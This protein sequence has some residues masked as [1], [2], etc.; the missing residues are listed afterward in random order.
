MHGGDIAAMCENTES[1]AN[2]I[3]AAISGTRFAMCGLTVS[4][5]ERTLILAFRADFEDDQRTC[6]KAGVISVCVSTVSP[7]SDH[8]LP[9]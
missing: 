3:P 9:T 2:E 6:N 1:I 7:Q 5:L 4:G 8:P